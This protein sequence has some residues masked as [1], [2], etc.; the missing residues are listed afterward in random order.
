[1]AHH[2]GSGLNPFILYTRMTPD[3][4]GNNVGMIDSAGKIQELTGVVN[5][6]SVAHA[7]VWVANPNFGLF[8]VGMF[9]YVIRMLLR[10]FEN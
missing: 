10:L 3:S 5:Q 4:V 9:P 1:M 2:I 7:G 6:I 8:F